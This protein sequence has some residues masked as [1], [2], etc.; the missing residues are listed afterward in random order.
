MSNY[1]LTIKQNNRYSVIMRLLRFLCFGLILLMPLLPTFAQEN[2]L[3]KSVQALQSDILYE[4]LLDYGLN[5]K[6][7]LLSN[8]LSN[9]FPYNIVLEYNA[10]I[11][12]ENKKKLILTFSQDILPY[13]DDI[14]YF[15]NYLSTTSIDYAIDILFSAN[16]L[17]PLNKNNAEYQSYSFSPQGSNTYIQSLVNKTHTAAIIITDETTINDETEN[18]SFQLFENLVEIIPGGTSSSNEANLVPLGFFKTI[19]NSFAE[20]GTN[21]YIKGY[22]LSLYRLHF[23]E[24]NILLGTWLENEIP[25]VSIKMTHENSDNIFIMLQSL[26]NNFNETNFLD[27]DINYT[28]FQFLSQTFFVSERLVLLLIILVTA[29][30][31]FGF[32]NLSFVTGVHRHIHK[33]EFLKI[34]YLIPIIVLLTAFFLF[35]SQN[36]VRSIFP[37]NLDFDI[38]AFILKIIF[39]VL[40]LLLFSSLQYLVKL[41]LTG[42]IYAYILSVSAASNIIIFSLV[43][44]T[45]APLF[46]CQYIIVQI[47]QRM[48]RI[49]P[50]VICLVL[51]AS[52]Y[53]PLLLN[54]V[55]SNQILNISSVLNS[56]F[57]INL[58][59]ACF[60]LP[61]QIMV[62][63]ILTRLKL[64][65]VR[66]KTNK[67]KI[68]KQSIVVISVVV[69]ITV[70]SVIFVQTQ[71]TSKFRQT[72]A[73]ED[74]NESFNLVNTQKTQFGN[75][76]QTLEIRSEMEVIRYDIELKS[77]NIIPIYDANYPYDIL[78]KPLSA[79]FTLD[80]YSPNPLVLNFTTQNNTDIHCY[81]DAWVKT[82]DGIEKVHID[83]IL[84]DNQ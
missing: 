81:I 83:Y 65:G 2:S 58:L 25:S 69:C 32:F 46:I 62:I 70:V 21:Y 63:R 45:L 50:I 23:I 5:P 51:M 71:S 7:Q 48:R 49:V 20:S 47:S 68:A 61:F 75:I 38:L 4:S 57:I 40:F 30:V 44:I 55:N 8:T 6:K 13:L 52:P 12:S 56:S 15:Y 84:Q 10:N 27:K 16:D 9:D 36:I 42:F 19:I 29:I 80:E 11:E 72:D 77:D 54:I 31:L 76:L 64:W 17:N 3:Q 22:F 24:D 14:V 39:S 34:W 73:V 35:V 78:S 67:K 74:I 33:K 28:F 1:V 41:P 18:N 59:L 60:M 37:S 79:I 66:S 82:P 26:I 53:F 43:E